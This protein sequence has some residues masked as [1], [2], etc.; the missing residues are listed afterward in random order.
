MP[1]FPPGCNW[2]YFSHIKNV[3]H[4]ILS[5]SAV[6]SLSILE[7]RPIL[8]GWQRLQQ[9]SRDGS[10]FTALGRT[11]K[12][13]PRRGPASSTWHSTREQQSQPGNA[14]QQAQEAAA[15]PEVVASNNH[16]ALRS[17]AAAQVTQLQTHHLTLPHLTPHP[18]GINDRDCANAREGGCRGG[19]AESLGAPE[20][21]TTLCTVLMQ[22]AAQAPSHFL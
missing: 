7:G 21:L 11:G 4:H 19:A 22:I 10:S 3:S 8:K 6:L 2:V 17:S 15:Q 13:G 16:M 14:T 5:P 20:S 12:R 9:Q 18:T 1:L